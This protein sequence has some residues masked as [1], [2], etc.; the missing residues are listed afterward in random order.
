MH[1]TKNLSV[2]SM[3]GMSL[4]AHSS[5]EAPGGFR[6]TGW[7]VIALARVAADTR[8]DESREC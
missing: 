1:E 2:G 7:A 6:D 3:T 8:V 5:L 4:F